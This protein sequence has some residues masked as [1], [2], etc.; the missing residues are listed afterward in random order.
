MCRV[1]DP[2]PRKWLG[3]VGSIVLFSFLEIG[4]SADNNANKESDADAH[5]NVVVDDSERDTEAEENRDPG[6]QCLPCGFLWWAVVG[7]WIG[8]LV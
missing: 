6:G 5:R 2:K 7:L 3:D 1:N 4:D 8:G